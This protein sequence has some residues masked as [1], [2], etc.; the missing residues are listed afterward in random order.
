MHKR[1]QRALTQ[2]G[3]HHN[4]IMV[5]L[6]LLEMGEGTISEVARQTALPRSTTQLAA[7]E[8]QT[9]GLISQ[10]YKREHQ[11]WFAESPNRFLAELHDKE[12]LVR[13]LLPELQLLR[14]STKR[15][16][17]VKYFSGAGS[18][19]HI[20]ED[21]LHA[22]QSIKMT[23]STTRL[24]DFL[25]EALVED[26]L[27]TVMTQ[28]V[29]VQLLAHDNAFVRILQDQSKTGRNR[30]RTYACEHLDRVFYAIY[31]SKVAVIILNPQELVGLIIED[32]GMCVS[33][34]YY[35]DLLWDTL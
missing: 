23:G 22:K 1:I 35:F 8:L 31:D 5:Y 32:D 26:F 14:R 18:V 27:R 29:P 11:V 3:Y 13:R 10:G 21:I 34:S 17:A 33:L 6:A 20:L 16:P 19:K 28:L 2:L 15:K 9:K 24:G 30:V 4:E 7:N 25:E 12:A